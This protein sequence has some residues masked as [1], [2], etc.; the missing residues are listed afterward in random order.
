[1][2]RQTGGVASGAIST[3][4]RSWRAARSSASRSGTTP[5]LVRSAS[6]RRTVSPRIASLIR[7]DGPAG[8][9]VSGPRLGG[10]KN[11]ARGQPRTPGFGRD[12]LAERHRCS[13]V[14]GGEK[15]TFSVGEDSSTR[16][17]RE[18][19]AAP[20]RAVNR[21]NPLRCETQACGPST[22]R[23]D[24][25]RMPKGRRSTDGCVPIANS[26]TAAART[27]ANLKPWPEKPAQTIRPSS[28]RSMT[29]SS[30]GVIA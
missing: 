20:L 27:G 17:E 11:L 2:I 18:V 3:R 5:T 9:R 15:V 14:S 1:M 22:H 24:H 12:A 30:V 26:A 21:A 29:G 10:T 7:V 16:R 13:D 28:S 8:G 6:I 25:D 23:G 4:S 19:R